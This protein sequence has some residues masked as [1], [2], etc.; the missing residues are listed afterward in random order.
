MAKKKSRSK[1]NSPSILQWVLVAAAAFLLYKGLEFVLSDHRPAAKKT[2][3][4]VVKLKP[5]EK[6]A[7]P[8]PAPANTPAPSAHA[9]PAP[10]PPPATG[11]VKKWD[12]QETARL[13]PAGSFPDN[14]AAI[15]VKDN[16]I[17]LLSHAKLIPGKKPGPKGLTN[18]RP[19]LSW[20]KLEGENYRTQELDFAPLKDALG[21]A[22]FLK[23]SGLPVV[24]K[25]P[26][27]KGDKS[28]FVSKLFLGEDPMEA[29]AIVQT[30]P[31][32]I[33]WANTIGADG[34]SRPAAFLT[35][36]TRLATKNFS[37]ASRGGKTYLIVEQ[38]Q[39]NEKR[40]HEG[41]RW[42]VSAF[43]WNGSSFVYDKDYSG[44]LTKKKQSE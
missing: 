4:P 33:H 39:L 11:A 21:N 17:G 42:E 35:G 15:P 27:L 1:K 20:N 32:G 29:V 38:G 16:E 5:K 28:L 24:E 44:E 3:S 25:S 41:Y 6:G 18:T 19:A 26:L 40:L 37:T 2:A 12:F 43:A 8:I 22:S 34:K 30:D 31:A 36:T 23:L 7:A 10:S 9:S 13:L 14:Y